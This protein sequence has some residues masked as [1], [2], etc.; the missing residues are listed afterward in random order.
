MGKMLV[1]MIIGITVFTLSAFALMIG[2][3]VLNLLK[4]TLNGFNE[5]RHSFSLIKRSSKFSLLSS[6]L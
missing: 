6:T 5:F 3:K 2:G 1:A 4:I